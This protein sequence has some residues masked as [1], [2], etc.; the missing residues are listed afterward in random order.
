MLVKPSRAVLALFL[1]CAACLFRNL[2]FLCG[3]G[4][5]FF[6]GSGDP[7]D[8]PSSPTRRS[9]DL[10]FFGKSRLGD[11]TSLVRECGSPTMTVRRARCGEVRLPGL[12]TFTFFPRLC[13]PTCLDGL[14]TAS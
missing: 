11:W 7:R 2:L 5:F 14:Q 3:F 12:K 1:G 9:S 4:F 10:F 8:L 6:K 13:R